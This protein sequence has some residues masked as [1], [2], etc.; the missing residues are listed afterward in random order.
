MNKMEHNQPV[1]P[2][3]NGKLGTDNEWGQNWFSDHKL[4]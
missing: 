3:C 2:R 1:P 4:F